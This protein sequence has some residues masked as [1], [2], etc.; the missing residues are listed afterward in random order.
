MIVHMST[1]APPSIVIVGAGGHGREL[2]WALSAAIGAGQCAGHLAGFVDDRPP[3]AGL[4]DRIGSVWLGPMD[5]LAELDADLVLGIGAPVARV[6]VA[7]R[8]ASIGRGPVDVMH[9][10][11]LIGPDVEWGEGFAACA[12]VS[13][14]TNVRF[15]VHVHLN[16][17]VTVGHDCVV[18]DF[19]SL[20]PA[21]VLSGNVSVGARTMIGAGAVVLPGVS[22][23]S[24]VQVGAGAVVTKDVLD[25][26]TVV[27]VPAKRMR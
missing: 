22:I 25:G 23:G 18:G 26:M 15:G 20:H 16:R 19:V 14:T 9:P 10:S 12:N 17:H 8:V 3:E 5:V 4:L 1:P 27:G 7:A 21:A 6:A 24:D 13:V 11:V 2:Y